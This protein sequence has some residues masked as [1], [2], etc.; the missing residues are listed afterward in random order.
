MNID[1][2][3]KRAIVTGSTDGIGFAVAEGLGKA[4]AHVIVT[5]REEAKTAAACE[6]LRRRSPQG[7][8][9]M[10]VADLGRVE[11]CAALMV[12]E[13]EADILVNV[14][15]IYETREFFALDD[16]DW[17]HLFQVNVMSGVRLSRHYAQGMRA[18]HWGRIQF[19]S[20]ESAINIPPDMLHYGVTKAALLGLSRG[21]AKAL[22]GSGVTVNA[23]LP[24]PTYTAGTRA[25]VEEMA[26]ERGLS[27]EEMKARFV[28][29]NRPTSLIGRFAEPDE[30]AHLCVYAASPQASCTTG[31]ALRVE[32]GIVDSII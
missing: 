5:G 23:I 15:G 3:G 29:E 18:R 8:Y 24:G 27:H 2:S 7:S 22:A 11:G 14:L 6:D 21:L 12:A 19:I 17:E 10:V 28:P 16:A 32:G 31:A 20:S 25:M 1:L 4:G 9:S 30:V 26:A 13:P